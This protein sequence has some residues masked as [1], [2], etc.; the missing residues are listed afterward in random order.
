MA[1]ASFRPEVPVYPKPVLPEAQSKN[2]MG[3]TY[4]EH[5]TPLVSL[6]AYMEGYPW[7]VQSYYRQVLGEHNDLKE[8]DAGLSPVFQSYSRIDD[9]ELRVQEDLQSSTDGITQFTQI[10]GGALVYGFII[11]NVNDYFVA[12][13]SY[14]RSILFR[15]LA[16]DRKTWRRESVFGIQYTSVGYTEELPEIMDA[17]KLKTTTEYVFSRDRLMEGLAPI[18]KTSDYEI[19]SNLKHSRELMGKHYLNTFSYTSTRTLN[20]PGQPGLRCYDSFL[21]N[22][23]MATFGYLEFPDVFKIKQL[24]TSGDQYLEEPQFWT[25]ILNRSRDDL[26]YGNKIMRMART[27]AIGRTTFIKTLY[28]SRMD[29]IIYP[30]K[31]DESMRSGNDQCPFPTVIEKVKPTTNAIGQI[32]TDE[33]KSYDLNGRKILAYPMV[34]THGYYVLSKAFYDNIS[35]ELTLLEIMTRDYLDSRTLDIKQLS[36]MIHLYPKM[37]RMEQFYFGPLL[38]CMLRYADQR[39]YSAV[40]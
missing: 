38:M 32:L 8:V 24:P 17:L 39:T 29:F 19:V 14:G 28:T 30:V 12:E 6:M 9:L 31:P 22:F 18:L 2:Y 33:Q 11:P 10:N 35:E 40:A 36:F 34:D 37:E 7:T 3:L 26:E 13:T 16:V 20:L 15:V 5:Q 4:D 23:V 27:A 25:A 21:V 1:I